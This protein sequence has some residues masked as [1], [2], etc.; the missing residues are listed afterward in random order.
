M[1]IRKLREK[2]LPQLAKLYAQ[3]WNEESDVSK[4]KESLDLIEKERN[5]I[6]LVAEEDGTLLGSVMGVV[7]RELYGD[8]KP[9]MVIENM[10]VNKTS[11][12]KGIGTKLIAELEAL[13]KKRECT[14]MILVTEK[15]RAD[16]CGFYESYGF[17]TDTTGYKKKCK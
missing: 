13:A 1:L 16:A 5:H 9:F 15:N 10:I 7:C 8:C 14:Q 11:R 4:M 2:D 6:I 17:Q 12:G 3:F